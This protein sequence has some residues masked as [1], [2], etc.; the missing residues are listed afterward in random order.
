MTSKLDI[1]LHHWQAFSLSVGLENH[2]FSGSAMAPSTSTPLNT[3][4]ASIVSAQRRPAGKCYIGSPKQGSANVL[5]N[6]KSCA[7]ANSEAACYQWQ[8]MDFA[9]WKTW[10]LVLE[11]SPL[12]L[13]FLSS[14]LPPCPSFFL[15]KVQGICNTRFQVSVSQDLS[16]DGIRQCLFDLHLSF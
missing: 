6:A 8:S 16:G 9:V 12:L 7:E 14:C 2:I 4:R 1:C 11:F 10:C 3:G 13:H 5:Y 15:P